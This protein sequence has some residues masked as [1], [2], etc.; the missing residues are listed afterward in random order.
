MSTYDEYG[1]V[2]LTPEELRDRVVAELGLTFEE[3]DSSYWN[4]LYYSAH[5]VD[6]EE[7]RIVDNRPSDEPEGPPYAEEYPEFKAV[8]SVSDTRRSASLA[9]VLTAIADVRHLDHTELGEPPPVGTP[10]SRDLFGATHRDLHDLLAPI[11][12]ALGSALTPA[13]NALRGGEFFQG[14]GP[15]L[16]R[17]ELVDNRVVLD[18]RPYLAGFPG[19]I[20]VVDVHG[21]VRSAE[22]RERLAAVE[23][24]ALLRHEE[25]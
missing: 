16:E 10:R 14:S 4:G 2:S 8:L 23:G 17:L 9:T 24:L 6:G 15:H 18:G 7:I 13:Y 3:R 12:E 11:G 22:L 1:S 19:V 5:G 25:S 20:T 21:T